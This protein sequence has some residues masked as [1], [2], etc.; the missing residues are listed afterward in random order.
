MNARS[1]T[2]ASFVIDRT[3]AAAPTRVFAAFASAEAKARWFAG[4]ASW[5]LVDRSMDFRVGGRER[6][7]GSFAGG[8]TSTF[9]AQYFDIVENERL[10][11]AYSM[12]L[13]DKHISVSLATV[14]LRP[15]AGG[16]RLLYTEQGAFLDGYDDA[17]SREQGSRILFDN[18]ARSLET[19]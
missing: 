15:A 12:H 10:V 14:E 18:L 2:H 9:E 19:K 16:T 5:K 3:F 17:G 1:T 4:P 11:Y 7:Q 8:R 6:L 13:D